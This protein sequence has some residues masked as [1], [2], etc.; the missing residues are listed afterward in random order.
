MSFTINEYSIIP[1]EKRPKLYVEMQTNPYNLE[2]LNL[3]K[4]FSYLDEKNEKI[5]NNIRSHY[6][7][8][9]KFKY[10]GEFLN[11]VNFSILYFRLNF[12][13]ILGG[14]NGHSKTIFI[15]LELSTLFCSMFLY[16][17][18][19]QSKK[20]MS[21]IRL[22]ILFGVM[23]LILSRIITSSA[24]MEESLHRYVNNSHLN[25]ANSSFKKKKFF[26]PPFERTEPLSYIK[27]NYFVFLIFFLLFNDYLTNNENS[28]MITSIFT[29]CLILIISILHELIVMKIRC[30]MIG[31]NIYVLIPKLRKFLSSCS[32]DMVL[33]VYIINS[34][35]CVISLSYIDEYKV[36]IALSISN[37]LFIV[38][39][40][41]FFNYKYHKEKLLI[42]GMWDTPELTKIQ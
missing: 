8:V 10:Y 20:A 37:I 6:Y 4:L 39:Y 42:K 40:P 24:R 11:V 12:D 25:K 27:I 2:K 21:E 14:Q 33:I 32:D 38:F 1:K 23:S 29:S 41:Q 22:I 28:S 16:L 9:M 31:I 3:S 34:V 15:F 36:L 30:M 26:K 19:Y 7:R 18:I 13:V 5:N 35:V 17:L